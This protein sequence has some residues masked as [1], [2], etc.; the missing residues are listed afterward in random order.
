[1]TLDNEETMESDPQGEIESISEIQESGENQGSL[2]WLIVMSFGFTLL[3]TAF[4][5]GSGSQRSSCH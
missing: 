5:T 3:F 4:Q 2:L 1:M